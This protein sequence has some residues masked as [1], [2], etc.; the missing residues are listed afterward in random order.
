[1]TIQVEWD[2]Q[3]QEFRGKYYVRTRQRRAEDEFVIRHDT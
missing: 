3:L 2:N 1:M